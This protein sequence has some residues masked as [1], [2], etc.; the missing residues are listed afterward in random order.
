MISPLL[1]VALF[2]S[3][4]YLTHFETERSGFSGLQLASNCKLVR[5]DK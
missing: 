4:S 5:V 1:S 3:Q 2:P